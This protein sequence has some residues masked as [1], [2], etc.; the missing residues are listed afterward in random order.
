MSRFE[1][2]HREKGTY[3]LHITPSRESGDVAQ[4]CSFHAIHTRARSFFRPTAILNL[5]DKQTT[6][7]GCAKEP[8]NL[9]TTQLWLKLSQP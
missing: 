7:M 9:L 4:I 6:T 5:L 3:F 2:P 8:P 1:F